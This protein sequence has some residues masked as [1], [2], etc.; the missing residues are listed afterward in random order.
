M[1]ETYGF[2]L[3]SHTMV[4]TK[5]REEDEE[6]VGSSFILQSILTMIPYLK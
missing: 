1:S 5:E 3:K 2:A 6:S 4:Y